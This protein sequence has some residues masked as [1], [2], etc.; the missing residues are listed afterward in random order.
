MNLLWG[1]YEWNDN[2]CLDRLND[3]H[4]IVR[5]QSGEELYDG[6]LVGIFLLR[7]AQLFSYV[8]LY[9]NVE[10]DYWHEVGFL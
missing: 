7:C 6:H 10:V 8:V 2:F 9:K 5:R 1:F 4:V 3:E